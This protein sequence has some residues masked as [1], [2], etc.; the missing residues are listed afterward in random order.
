VSQRDIVVRHNPGASRFEADVE[1][2]IAHADYRMQGAVMRIVHA[3]VPRAAEGRGIAAQVV[4]AAL[5]HARRHGL[6][7]QPMCSYVRSYMSR[8]PETHD[9][10]PAGSGD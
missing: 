6:R 10:L 4:R 8:H 7:V 3:E 1:G 9:L 2:G 5:E